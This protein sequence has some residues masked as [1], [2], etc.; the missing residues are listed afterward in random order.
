MFMF[1]LNKQIIL[2]MTCKA[3]ENNNPKFKDVF[4][5]TILRL[6][7]NYHNNYIV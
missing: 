2:K 4:I 5:V 1:S 7:N 3:S 6:I